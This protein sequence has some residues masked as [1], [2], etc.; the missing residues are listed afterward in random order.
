MVEENATR[1]IL[2]LLIVWGKRRKQGGG[3]RR[4]A[5]IFP[6]PPVERDGCALDVAFRSRYRLSSVGPKSAR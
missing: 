1:H 2:V 6:G 4:T 3:R 5:C